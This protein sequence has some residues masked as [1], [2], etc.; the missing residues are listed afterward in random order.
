MEML[1]RFMRAT[2]HSDSCFHHV[3]NVS[4][5]CFKSGFIELLLCVEIVH[6]HSQTCLWEYKL[7]KCTSAATFIKGISEERCKITPLVR[8]KYIYFPN[9][10]LACF[11][12]CFSLH[13]KGM[14][15]S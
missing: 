9:I 15:N 6:T 10:Q 5:V 4:L 13:R 3:I 8:V 14:S 2:N 1:V 11:F 12:K 7:I